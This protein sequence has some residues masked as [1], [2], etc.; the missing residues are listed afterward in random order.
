[1]D[2][3]VAYIVKQI[4]A[5]I[6]LMLATNVASKAQIQSQAS[7]VYTPT[8]SERLR[9][10]INVQNWDDGGELTHFAYLHV[11][12]VFLTEDIHRN[13]PCFR[14]GGG[15]RSESRGLFG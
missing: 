14:P 7:R 2:G 3:R 9:P 4:A 6:L 5:V 15:P 8:E 10:A 13:G 12:Q 11:S 1:M